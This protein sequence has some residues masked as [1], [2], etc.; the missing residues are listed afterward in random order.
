MSE[1]FELGI[2]AMPDAGRERFVALRRS[3]GLSIPGGRG[4]W[5]TKAK[6]GRSLALPSEPL[7]GSFHSAAHLTHN[8]TIY[9]D[10]YRPTEDSPEEDLGHLVLEIERA[11][12]NQSEAL[13]VTCQHR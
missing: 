8:G 10:I 3:A 13:I 9:C 11:L 2:P 6:L 5:R 4:S 7:T 1:D 12:A